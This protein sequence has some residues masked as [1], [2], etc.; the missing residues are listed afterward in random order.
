MV[1]CA[2]NGWFSRAW[3]TSFPGIGVAHLQ[4]SDLELPVAGSTLVPTVPAF[5]NE[6]RTY[7]RAPL[8]RFSS[9]N[10]SATLYDLMA[11]YKTPEEMFQGAVI[12]PLLDEVG[13]TLFVALHGAN[14]ANSISI[15]EA[16]PVTDVTR[17]LNT[18][19]M[20]LGDYRGPR[21]I[22]VSPYMAKRLGYDA[23]RWSLMGG[24]R[25]VVMRGCEDQT[26]LMYVM[27]MS[28]LV[29]QVVTANEGR[30][31][32]G[33]SSGAPRAR[34]YFRAPAYDDR[35]NVVARAYLDMAVEVTADQLMVFD[36]SADGPVLPASEQP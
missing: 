4:L 34:L 3:E 20:A 13:A 10:L 5:N 24:D 35:Q 8:G 28:D 7:S 15:P 31:L 27:P 11:A 33:I 22:L 23:A 21:L 26:L 1:K 30:C 6:S 2:F 14:H 12:D 29:L 18:T 19:F 25:F 36:L 16:L 17:F 9:P 32:P